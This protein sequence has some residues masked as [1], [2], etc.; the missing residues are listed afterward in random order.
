MVVGVDVVGTM[1]TVFGVQSGHVVVVAGSVVVVTAVLDVVTTAVD[2]DE[3][4]VGG[5][6]VVGGTHGFVVVV[7]IVVGG[8]VG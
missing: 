6:V 5:T 2:V 3:D 8:Y 1:T 4:D 7:A